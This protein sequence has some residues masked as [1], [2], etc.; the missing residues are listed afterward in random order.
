MQMPLYK[1]ILIPPSKSQPTT[2][3]QQELRRKAESQAALALG[4]VFSKKSSA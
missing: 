1:G 2:P 3:Q 4:I